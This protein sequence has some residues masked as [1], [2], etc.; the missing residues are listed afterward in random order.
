MMAFPIKV[1]KKNSQKGTLVA[2]I[3]LCQVKKDQFVSALNWVNFPWYNHPTCS[4]GTTKFNSEPHQRGKKGKQT[5][6]QIG[7]V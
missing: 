1:A 5:V 6:L 2:S 7:E 4:L 3:T